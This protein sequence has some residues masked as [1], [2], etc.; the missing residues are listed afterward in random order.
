MSLST[1]HNKRGT[2]LGAH[3]PE[4]AKIGRLF[5]GLY[6]RLRGRLRL[7]FSRRHIRHGFFRF[8]RLRGR[9]ELVGYIVINL[10]RTRA[11]KAVI[12]RGVNSIAGEFRTTQDYWHMARIFANRPALNADFVMSTPTDRIF[13]ATEQ[14]SDQLYCMVQ[15]NIIA[16]RLVSK[17]GNPI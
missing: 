15:N 11:D 13:Q 4:A 5:G 14:Q 10:I 17:N 12:K 6:L 1:V 3:L 9:E 7:L 2:V 8:R 16:R